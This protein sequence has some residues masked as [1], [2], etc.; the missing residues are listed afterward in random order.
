MH[1]AAAMN[2]NLK[3]GIW[4]FGSSPE[5]IRYT[6]AHGVN[7]ASDPKTREA[8]MPAFG[9]TLS[10]DKIHILTAWVYGLTN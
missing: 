7:D 5:A 2:D 8:V 9:E 10:E 6:I 3:D 1:D 4:R